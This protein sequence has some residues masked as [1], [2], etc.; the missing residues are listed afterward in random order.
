MESTLSGNNN[1]SFKEIKVKVMQKN[2]F[3][4]PVFRFFGEKWL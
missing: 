2:V 3:M 4:C 1:I